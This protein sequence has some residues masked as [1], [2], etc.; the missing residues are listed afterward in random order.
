VRARRGLPRGAFVCEYVGEVVTDAEACART[1]RRM[2]RRYCPALICPPPAVCDVV[3]VV[4]V[5]VPV[6]FFSQ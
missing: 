3:T 2:P 4:A 5:R 6:L 1:T